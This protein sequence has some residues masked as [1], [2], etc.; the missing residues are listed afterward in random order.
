MAETSPSPNNVSVKFK[1]KN[2]VK[3]TKLPKHVKQAH[4]RGL[5]SDKAMEKIRHG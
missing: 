1:G 2:P 3:Q 4:K 5:I